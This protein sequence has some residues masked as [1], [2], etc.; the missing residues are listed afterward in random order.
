MCGCGRVICSSRGCG[1]E[2]CGREGWALD[3]GV[4]E[5]RAVVEGVV[6]KVVV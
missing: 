2:G 4:V 6:K 1:R 5:L 3:E